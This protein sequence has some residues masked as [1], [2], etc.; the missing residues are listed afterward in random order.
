MAGTHPCSDGEG[1]RREV[2]YMH[3]SCTVWVVGLRA[4]TVCGERSEII[5]RVVTAFLSLSFPASVC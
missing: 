2:E 1:E 3:S 5:A 4:A